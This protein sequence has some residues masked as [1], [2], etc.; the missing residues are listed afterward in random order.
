MKQEDSTFD[1]FGDSFDESMIDAACKTINQTTAKTSVNKQT[2]FSHQKISSQFN[3]DLDDLLSEEEL[4]QTKPVPE[5]CCSKTK[6]GDKIVRAAKS[7][8]PPDTT[9]MT[10]SQFDID[11]DDLLSEEESDQRKPVLEP[12]T[13]K[14]KLKDN[15]SK[16]AA[17]C[18]PS[19]STKMTSSQFD[20]N[21]DDLLS[22]GP[23]QKL[24]STSIPPLDG[25]ISSNNIA[26]SNLR[27]DSQPIPRTFKNCLV[28]ART[29]VCHYFTLMC[30]LFLH[31]QYSNFFS[32]EK[33][34]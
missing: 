20:I 33:Y 9:K 28:F 34:P 30:I 2:N 8:D 21:V 23:P 32:I 14:T 11:L 22:P 10:S 25:G 3:I 27:L 31:L 18:G 17:S 26:I 4:D 24:S 1:L 16:T 12:C 7:R 15:N 29:K 19:D 6:L 5:P 13:T